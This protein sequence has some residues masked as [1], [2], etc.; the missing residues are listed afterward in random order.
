MQPVALTS[1]RIAGL[2]RTPERTVRD[3]L[4]K[5]HATD[6]AAGRVPTVTKV[7]RPVGGVRW[8]VPLDA[9]CARVGLTP[10]VVLLAA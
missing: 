9:Y 6:V 3:R 2:T 1:A 8:S 5:W 7:A 10:D 4:A